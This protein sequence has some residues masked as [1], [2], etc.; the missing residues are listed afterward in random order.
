MLQAGLRRQAG[1]RDGRGGGIDVDR[2]WD[3]EQDNL[4]SSRCPDLPC[5]SLLSRLRV[6]FLTI[7]TRT[8][9]IQNTTSQ[10][11][12][13]TK[14]KP[15]EHGAYAIVGI[16][17]ITALVIAGP[18][19]AG[20]C[21]AVAAVTGFLAHEPLL[22]TLGHR[23]SRAQRTT[24]AASRRLA[25]LVSIT[26][27]CGT[28]AIAMGSASVRWSLVLCGVLA[29]ASFALAIVGK[30]KTLGG[31]LFG[32]VGLS[33]PCVPIMLAGKAPL[34]LTLEAWST[35]LIGFAATTMAVRGVIA[36]QKRQARWLHW[37]SLG[38]LTLL[39]VLLTYR[40][41]QL[42][43]VTFPMLVMSWY[44]MV[45][46]PHAKQLKRV[47]WTLVVGTVASAIWMTRNA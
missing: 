32:V 27:A 30:H 21:V 22:V 17:I 31:Q 47:G 38:G 6:K 9:T 8:A 41:M 44:L 1:R 15:K 46:P 4:V 10:A 12:P 29:T 36:T 43:I 45:D 13:A 2:H 39:V 18:T 40:A 37:W 35:W 16:P 34:A 14:L 3:A 19:V 5:G 28:V 33:V 25:V 42:P 20:V 7:I 11:T 24:P 23:G 26:V